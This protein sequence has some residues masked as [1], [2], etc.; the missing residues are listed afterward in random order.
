M[1]PIKVS[2]KVHESF[3]RN[4]AVSEMTAIKMCTNGSTTIGILNP[5]DPVSDQLIRISWY[6]ETTERLIRFRVV[7]PYHRDCSTSVSLVIHPD[8][9][10]I[11]IIANVRSV[12]R[13]RKTPGLWKIRP[14][15]A[16][17]QNSNE[18]GR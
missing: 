14:I 10:I 12:S 17:I 5:P 9:S 15:C 6:R 18:A 11:Q 1:F 4:P 8:Q 3:M 16:I 7:A 13:A 2:A